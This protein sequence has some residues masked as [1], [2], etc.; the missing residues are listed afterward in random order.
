M[1]RPHNSG[2]RALRCREAASGGPSSGV[3]G[4]NAGDRSTILRNS[5]RRGGLSRTATS[6]IRCRPMLG[7]LL[8]GR[9]LTGRFCASQAPG[10]SRVAAPTDDRCWIAT[11]RGP[12]RMLG[13]R[14]P[15][16]AVR[17]NVRLLLSRLY[18]VGRRANMPLQRRTRTLEDSAAGTQRAA[19][20]EVRGF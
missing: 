7:V 16:T 18:Y 13:R 15:M 11:A 3:S 20:S 1:V 5:T 2:S 19:C 9:S 10:R 12:A 6:F 8:L 4:Q 17:E 14:W